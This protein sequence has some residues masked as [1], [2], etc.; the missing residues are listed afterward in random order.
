M[1][2]TVLVVN[3][4]AFFFKC[5]VLFYDSTFHIKLSIKLIWED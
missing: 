3:M 4:L 2:V 1:Y 5:D